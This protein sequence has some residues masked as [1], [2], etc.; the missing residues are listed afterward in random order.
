MSEG[1]HILS[2]RLWDLFQRAGADA[3]GCVKNVSLMSPHLGK[4]TWYLEPCVF[5]SVSIRISCGIENKEIR[6]WVP[7]IPRVLKQANL[8]TI[9]ALH[10]FLVLPSSLFGEL[11]HLPSDVSITVQLTGK[12]V[13]CI[14]CIVH[15]GLALMMSSKGVSQCIIDP[16]QQKRWQPCLPLITGSKSP[17]H[18]LCGVRKGQRFLPSHSG[19]TV[20]LCGASLYAAHPR[21]TTDEKKQTIKDSVSTV[22]MFIYYYCSL[23]RQPILPASHLTTILFTASLIVQ[24]LWVSPDLTVTPLWVF[25]AADAACDC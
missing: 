3:R 14:K 15:S 25:L 11:A 7:P 23:I 20:K 5:Q 21:L 1:C 17:E 2:A 18:T 12:C 9:T 13:M 4:L 6:Y 24:L 16:W 10:I 22:C 8:S 19:I